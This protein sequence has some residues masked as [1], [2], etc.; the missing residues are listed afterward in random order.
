MELVFSKRFLKSLGRLTDDQAAA[1]KAALKQFMDDNHHPGLN[2]E[3][4]KSTH[5][6]TIRVNQGDRVALRRSGP[7]QYEVVD[8]GSH[9]YIYRRYG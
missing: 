5:Y 4:V 2:F 8:V 6:C 3:K 1:T 7:Q 9:D